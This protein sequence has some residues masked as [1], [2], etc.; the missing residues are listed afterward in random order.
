MTHD[1]PPGQSSCWGLVR[2]RAAVAGPCSGGSRELW[3]TLTVSFTS[4]RSVFGGGRAAVDMGGMAQER[5]DRG[6]EPRLLPH[7]PGKKWGCEV[8]VW[9]GG[10][11]GRKK[12]QHL[13]TCSAR[14]VP[15]CPTQP[16]VRGPVLRTG[17]PSPPPAAGDWAALE[18]IG[19]SSTNTEKRKTWPPGASRF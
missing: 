9:K 7:R 14:Q 3:G 4:G 19:K 11:G 1:L 12:K 13:I 16:S 2:G 6:G 10:E 5:E 15:A 8:S 17:G 18:G